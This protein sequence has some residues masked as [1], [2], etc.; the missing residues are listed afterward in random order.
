M[1]TVCDVRTIEGGS[2]GLSVAQEVCLAELPVLG[3]DGYEPRWEALEPN[4]FKDT[5]ETPKLVSRSPI[6]ANRQNLK[7]K[8]AGR[9]AKLGFDGDLTNSRVFR[10]LM[11][12]FAFAFAHEKPSTR[13]LN[14]AAVPIT[15]IAAADDSFNAASG[16]D[17]FLPNHLVLA[18]GVSVANSGLHKVATV[19]AGKVTVASSLA[20][21]AISGG[22]ER[23]EVV[24][25][26]FPA[27]GLTLTVGTAD[28]SLTIP[29]L[30]FA[31]QTLTITGATN[32]VADE[33]VTIGARTYTFKAAS[34]AANQVTIGADKG[35]TLANLAAAIN[36]SA[37][38]GSKYGAGT[39]K[40]EQVTATSNGTAVIVTAVKAGTP[41]NAIAT[42]ETMTNGAW[43]A[44]TLAGGTGAIGWKG[45][46][47][48][49]GEWIGIGGDDALTGFVNNNRAGYGRV[50]SVTESVLKLDETTFT[51]FDDTAAAQTVQ[52]FFGTLVRNEPDAENIVQIPFQFEQTLGKDSAGTQ[53]RYIEGSIASDITVT[54]PLEDKV[55]FD[56]SFVAVKETFRTG[57]EGLKEG[58]RF[59]EKGLEQYNTNSDI[60]RIR[61]GS[62]SNLLNDDNFV[63]YVNQG[64][65]AIKNGVT[66]TKALGERYAID[67]GSG[68]FEV[69][70]SLTGYF[71]T[72]EAIKDARNNVD[73][74]FNV[75][76]AMNNAGM[77]FDVP[78][79]GLSVGSLDIAL[80]E[81]VKIPIDTAAGENKYG[82]T[83]AATFFAYLP[84]SLMP[85]N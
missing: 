6:R 40:N 83:L 44:A 60:Y 37:G 81:K 19:A 29:G 75:I 27:G 21:E 84:D 17:I 69:S 9:D 25:Y 72:V 38:A 41:A 33:T 54:M 62:A 3:I 36:G 14:K 53:A 32:A 59:S 2:V 39:A 57:L 31:S 55:T 61:L 65:L 46:G 28:V 67:M 16:L 45:L 23:L 47:V 73:A 30:A 24:G 1:A 74:S 22:L 76:L 10:R 85:L 79:L 77:V 5:G 50:S 51:P 43:G 35:V 78:L 66:A 56:M 64:S 15:G 7:G 18:S 68:N 13:S 80:N 26:Q 20:D 34:A 71:T 48:V 11:Q 58:A 82:Y 63:M 42:T 8:V 12:G 52:V 49:V 4:S 70:G